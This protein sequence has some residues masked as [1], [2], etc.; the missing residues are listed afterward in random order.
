M[1][2][3]EVGRD[4]MSLVS[5]YVRERDRE[6]RVVSLVS[7]ERGYT[8]GRVRRVV[9]NEFGDGELRG[10]VVLLIVD[11]NTEVLFEGLIDS[12]GLPVHL[13][14]ISSQQVGLDVERSA[15]GRP[16][17]GDE[18]FSSVGNDV[19]REAVFREDVLYEESRGGVGSVG[20]D[21]D[22]LLG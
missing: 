8:S 7:V 13:W 22:G 14:V 20:G 16:E 21:E 6:S 5:G 3:L 17:L 12:F 2:S 4:L 19:S 11:V 18:Q 1:E 15:Q 9:V 10:P